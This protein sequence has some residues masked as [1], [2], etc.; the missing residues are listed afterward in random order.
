MQELFFKNT[1]KIIRHYLIKNECNVDVLNTLLL[2]GVSSFRYWFKF[3]TIVINKFI[4]KMDPDLIM[5]NDFNDYPSLNNSINKE[6]YFEDIYKCYQNMPSFLEMIN[7]HANSQQ[8]SL[9]CVLKL[10]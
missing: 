1:L 5:S 8:C 10:N 3:L 2:Q 6:F 9:N 4:N 7:E